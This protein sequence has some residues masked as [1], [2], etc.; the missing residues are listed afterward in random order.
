MTGGGVAFDLKNVTVNATASAFDISGDL[1]VSYEMANF[2][3]AT[4]AN[5]GNDVGNFSFSALA[6]APEPSRMI[7]SMLGIAAVF[8]RRRR[9]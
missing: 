2:Y 1:A 5:Q 4:P 7:F 8:M 6:M 3:L 9:C